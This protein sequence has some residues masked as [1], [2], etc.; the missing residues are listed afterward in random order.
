MRIESAELPF[1]GLQH[2]YLSR[3]TYLSVIESAELPFEGLQ[4]T[5]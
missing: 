5:F 1:E 4:H 2:E 3:S